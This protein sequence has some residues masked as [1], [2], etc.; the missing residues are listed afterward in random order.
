MREVGVNGSGGRI[1]KSPPAQIQREGFG[2]ILAWRG[3]A[4]SSR[5]EYNGLLYFG[6]Y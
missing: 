1:A 4:R 6:N 3:V 5:V 2:H